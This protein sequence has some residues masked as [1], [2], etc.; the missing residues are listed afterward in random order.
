MADFDQ[1][2]NQG[3]D[4]DDDDAARKKAEELLATAAKDPE[5]GNGPLT[6][7]DPDDKPMQIDLEADELL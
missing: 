4:P 2:A 3:G 1:F 5:L 7:D 6:S